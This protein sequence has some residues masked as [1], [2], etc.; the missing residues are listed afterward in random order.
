MSTITERAADANSGIAGDG[1]LTHYDPVT[2][3]LHWLTVALV[4][5]LMS[6]ALIWEEL[7]RPERAPLIMV[8]MSLGLILAAVVIARLVWR[9]V[10][11]HRMP[12]VVSGLTQLASKTVHYLLYALL[13]AQVV[14]GFLFRWSEG[15]ALSF[16]GLL[17]PAPF[18]PWS[19]A[20]HHQVGELH[21]NVGWAIIIVAGLHAAAA[22]YH[23]F[24]V[25]DRVLVRMIPALKPRR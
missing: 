24:V 7:P 25:R 20:A 13:A 22:L 12:P 14:L 18:Q 17:I 16:F 6:L 1:N 2:L 8:H 3:T 5:T 10:P 11:G 15:E 21:E 4:A 9:L 19:R 23:H